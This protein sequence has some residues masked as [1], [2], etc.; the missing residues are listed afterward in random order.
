VFDVDGTLA[1]IVSTPERASVPDTTRELLA[2]LN[3]RYGLVACLSG[4]RA[5]D[6]RRVVG[7]D[8]LIYMGN[9]GLEQLR[10]GAASPETV[11]EALAQS[12]AVRSFAIAAYTPDLSRLGV[13]IEDKESI[14]AYHWRG[15][16]DEASARQALEAIAKSASDQGL[17]P[18]WGRKVLEIR[19]AV[20]VDKG[21][22]I[23]RLLES[24]RP[25]GVLYGGDDTTDLA[26]FRRLREMRSSGSVEHAICVGVGSE[27][28]PAD[29][30]AEADLVVDGPGGFRELLSRL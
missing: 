27:E 28:G 24:P 18:H 16:P 26:A 23:G 9:H 1:P 4:R 11:P 3:R 10:P 12:P 13:R 5:A 22:A 19:P 21:T 14:W 25:H 2:D 7:L 8:T 30:S 6:A 29:I 20:A 17:V 15:A